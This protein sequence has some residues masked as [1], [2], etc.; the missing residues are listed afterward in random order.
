MKMKKK[1]EVIFNG[2]DKR[3]LHNHSF[4]IQQ[5]WGSTETLWI[6]IYGDKRLRSSQK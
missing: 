5:L 6:C 4:A 3:V 2:G 1:F